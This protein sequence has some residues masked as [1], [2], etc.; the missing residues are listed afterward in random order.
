M[1]TQRKIKPLLKKGYKFLYHHQFLNFM[2]DKNYIMLKFWATMD[3]SLDLKSPKTLSEK[4]QWLKLYDHNPKY[5]NLIDKY[6]VKKIVSDFIGKE[7][8]IETYQIATY[9]DEID[10]DNLPNQFV[11]KCTHDSASYIICKDK[12]KFDILQAKKKINKALKRNHFYKNREWAY[13]HIK[14][15]IIIEKYIED[16]PNQPLIDYKFMCSMGHIDNIMVCANRKYTGTEFYFFDIKWNF[17][18]FSKRT[19][20]Y[21][22]FDLYPKPANLDKMLEICSILSK[23][24]PFVRID[25]YNVNGKIYF[26]E[27]TLYPE[28]GFGS[29]YLKEVDLKFGNMFSI[30]DVKNSKL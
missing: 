15:R 1:N 20:P 14:P 28:G 5:A 11:I 27:I 7:Y 21:K 25:L 22:A 4:I 23:D 30:N 24:L 10:F 6:E 2:S 3:Y 18:E 29:E 17:F 12:S 13:K 16:E 9:F 8:V 26:G 19:L